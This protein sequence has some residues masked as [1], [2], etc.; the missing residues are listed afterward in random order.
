MT[1]NLFAYLF[2][3]VQTEKSYQLDSDFA[4]DGKDERKG[5]LLTESLMS[6]H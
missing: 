2:T 5:G 4:D 6:D 3:V 1:I